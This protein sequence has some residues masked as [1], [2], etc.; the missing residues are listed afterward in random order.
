MPAW[1]LILSLLAAPADRSGA[2]GPGQDRATVKPS[3]SPQKKRSKPSKPP[4][5]E[6]VP[7]ERDKP[8]TAMA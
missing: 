6:P 1:P 4:K 2:K 8:K 5:E 7:E 3:V